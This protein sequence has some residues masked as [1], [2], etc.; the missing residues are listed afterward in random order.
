ME[1]VVNEIKSF[2][3]NVETN[4]YSFRL[5][6]DCLVK[7]QIEMMIKD[8][9]ENDLEIENYYPVAILPCKSRK[10]ALYISSNYNNITNVMRG[11]NN[12]QPINDDNIDTQFYIEFLQ[13]CY[14]VHI[15]V[16]TTELVTL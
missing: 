7:E 14:L 2:E 15:I 6:L 5:P 1:K 3:Y 13:D 4:E 11:S 10:D 8:L 16:K 9:K 12:I